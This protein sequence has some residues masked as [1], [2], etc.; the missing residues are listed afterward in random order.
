MRNDLSQA[1]VDAI[2]APTRKPVMWADF[3]F[4]DETVRI[5][6]GSYNRS[7]IEQ[8]VESWGE[9]MD[10]TDLYAVVRGG[11]LEARSMSI[12]VF[13][14]YSTRFWE[15]FGAFGLSN[16]EVD[17]YIGCY[18]DPDNSGVLDSILI[19]T[20]I[21]QEPLTFAESDA[22]VRIDLVSV[23]MRH[24]PYLSGDEK[25]DKNRLPYVVGHAEKL[26][27]RDLQTAHYTQ[28]VEAVDDV[29]EGNVKVLNAVGFS[30]SDFYALIDGELIDCRK[31]DDT[32]IV[33]VGRGMMDT[34]PEAHDAHAVVSI[35]R[36]AYDYG[37]CV[38]PVESMSNLVYDNEVPYQNDYQ[39]IPGG[40]YAIVRF[41]NRPPWAASEP[42]SI[43]DPGGTAPSF[44][45]MAFGTGHSSGG[46]GSVSNAQGI[47]NNSETVVM[48]LVSN[49]PGGDETTT[50][51]PG[52]GSD[53]STECVRAMALS[54]A[55][56]FD[57]SPSN[58]LGCAAAEGW[59]YYNRDDSGLGTFVKA[60]VKVTVTG[61]H[62]DCGGS[63]YI[64][65]V[66]GNGTTQVLL[67]EWYHGGDGST[68]PPWNGREFV[69]PLNVTSW[70]ELQGVYIHAESNVGSTYGSQHRVDDS[71]SVTFTVTYNNIPSTFPT[72]E[73]YV[74]STYGRD[75]QGYG[76]F[77]YC[78]V[79][80]P[81]STTVE[82]AV[83][84]R[85]LIS[86]S[87]GLPD[88]VI[89]SDTITS[90]QGR[91][92]LYERIVGGGWDGLKDASIRFVQKIVGPEEGGI[93]RS[94]TTTIDYVQWEVTYQ[95]PDLEVPP[96]TV[97][98][99][100]DNLRCDVTKVAEDVTPARA[101][102]A[103]LLLYGF[104][105]YIDETSFNEAHNVYVG[106]NY[107]ISG[108][109]D[110]NQRLHDALRYLLATGLT[111]LKYNA[112]KIG[113][114][115]IDIPSSNSMAFT[116]NEIQLKSMRLESL[117][118]D[119]MINDIVVMYDVQGVTEQHKGSYR[120][121][122]ADSVERYGLHRKRVDFS[123]VRDSAV[124]ELIAERL[125]D[126]YDKPPTI[127][128]F[129]A[130]M[131]TLPLEK[132]DWIVFES[133]FLGYQKGRGRVGSVTRRFA[134]AKAGM[135]HLATIRLFEPESFMLTPFFLDV[136]SLYEQIVLERGREQNEWDLVHFADTVTTFLAL[137][138]NL[139]L[140]D[141]LTLTDS[142]TA[143]AIEGGYGLVGYG[144][145]PY[146][147]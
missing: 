36:E 120:E 88:T 76:N 49:V 83:V 1:L 131:K 87:P 146:G 34:N 11:A 81:I 25:E 20:F 117:T 101:I 126:K 29:Y 48:S 124:A 115:P 109:I 41:M 9:L 138:L 114:V 8:I 128:S 92:V 74:E 78:Y 66:Y 30:T 60:T 75:D 45:Y 14:N 17:V 127:L 133:N 38:G 23:I 37:V 15:H 100:L 96:T 4:P 58:P 102:Q 116:A 35:Y 119:E 82:N 106:H 104:R 47:N 73:N 118:L 57:H 111:R 108:S 130:Y 50:I 59:L 94:A 6:D 44:S 24:N 65:L 80:V 61:Y 72:V 40:D 144:I 56:H 5:S 67:D 18:T 70:A 28:L 142:V 122:R 46:D 62:Y 85:S 26:L 136:I 16:I 90:T 2:T 52:R 10:N 69:V 139:D 42:G 19:D 3:K 43:I 64:E 84:E 103:L 32:T 63:M 55:I 113:L 33:F 22:L 39:F 147:V 77:N 140:S 54:P 51:N 27:L 95:A 79:I 98:T 91:Q 112:G 21:C 121:T 97:T 141:T 86:R 107:Y 134:K 132:Q 137:P 71:L 13:N 125:L 123:M 93:N 68:Y 7:D 99:F 105:E 129:K 110:G 12:T 53:F 135:I 31:V 145:G 143:E 89:W